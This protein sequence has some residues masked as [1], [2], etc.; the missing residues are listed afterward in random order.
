MRQF[1]NDWMDVIDEDLLIET[2]NN[3]DK[4]KIR[5]KVRPS[6]ECTFN[7]FLECDY[8]NLKI[9][10]VGQDPYPQLG[11]ATGLCFA[12]NESTTKELYSPSLKILKDSIDAYYD[13]LPSGLFNPDLKYLAHQGILMLNCALT[14]RA[15]SI[16]SHTMIWRPFVSKLLEN[17]SI[18]KPN[19]IFVL[20]GNVAQTFT[21]YIKSDNIIKCV[22]PAFCARNGG[23]L[24]D[25]FSVIDKKMMQQNKDL[26][27]WK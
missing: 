5:Y 27:Y 18:K 3:I 4:D 6:Q 2:L 26:I 13:D 17:I 11:V 10:F 25:I 21:P 7:A 12:N 14:V 19:T 8:N 23:L 22:H 1:F 15:N 16:G 20:F 24:P 9:V